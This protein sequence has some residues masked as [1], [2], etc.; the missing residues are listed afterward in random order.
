MTDTPT[1]EPEDADDADAGVPADA[2]EAFEALAFAR[3]VQGMT[4][5]GVQG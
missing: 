2:L 3:A 4:P 5:S 1:P